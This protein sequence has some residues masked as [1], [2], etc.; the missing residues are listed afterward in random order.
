M[1]DIL[2]NDDIPLSRLIVILLSVIV[3]LAFCWLCAPFG[4]GEES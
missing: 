2:E 3:T 4:R 1:Q